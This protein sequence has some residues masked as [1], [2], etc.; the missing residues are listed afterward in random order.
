MP[1]DARLPL[2]S[3]RSLPIMLTDAEGRLVTHSFCNVSP[4]LAL[5]VDQKLIV[6]LEE[7]RGL[8]LDGNGLSGLSPTDIPLVDNRRE[9]SRKILTSVCLSRILTN[10]TQSGLSGLAQRLCWIAHRTMPCSFHHRRGN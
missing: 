6:G 10:Q 2:H 7:W 3:S 8:V 5:T 9:K 4:E 1:W